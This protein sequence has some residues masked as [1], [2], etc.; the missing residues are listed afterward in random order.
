VP[1]I[2]TDSSRE[3]ILTHKHTLIQMDERTEGSS[4]GKSKAPDAN[5]ML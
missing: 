5:L 2:P 4:A 1:E 3:F